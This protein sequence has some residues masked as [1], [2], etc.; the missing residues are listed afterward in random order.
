MGF[1]DPLTDQSGNWH[2]TSY[3]LHMASFL[4]A[5]GDGEASVVSVKKEMVSVSIFRWI[6]GGS[7]CGSSESTS[8]KLLDFGHRVNSHG[9][10]LEAM[11]HNLGRYLIPKRS[12]C[13]MLSCNDGGESSDE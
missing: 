8:S 11:K 3:S 6:S 7:G 10:I 5:S 1:I 13:S 4:R 12:S 2:V 9:G